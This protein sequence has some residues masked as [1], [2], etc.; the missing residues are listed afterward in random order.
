MN[1]ALFGLAIGTAIGYMYARIFIELW[2][3]R[4]LIKRDGLHYPVQ[5]L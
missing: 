4:R 2:R 1:E 5:R 3:M